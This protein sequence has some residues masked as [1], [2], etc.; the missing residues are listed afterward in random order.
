MYRAC[1]FLIMAIFVVWPVNQNIRGLWGST[2]F[3]FEQMDGI[4]VAFA[5]EQGDE[6]WGT[7]DQAGIFIGRDPESGDYL[8]EVRPEEQNQTSPYGFG[9]INIHPEIYLPDASKNSSE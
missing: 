7:D 6:T 9:Q 8:L 4:R 1:L 3:S 5:Q 2:G